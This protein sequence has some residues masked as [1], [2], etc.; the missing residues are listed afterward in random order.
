[1]RA[2]I[3]PRDPDSGRRLFHL[4]I[5]KSSPLVLVG[6]DSPIAVEP[7]QHWF[8]ILDDEPTGRCLHCGFLLGYPRLTVTARGGD[9][10][11][12]AD[13]VA[14]DHAAYHCRGDLRLWEEQ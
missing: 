9:V 4:H 8:E 3:V 6:L 13:D 1:M 12:V 5:L 2:I 7:R 10:F 11:E 14:A